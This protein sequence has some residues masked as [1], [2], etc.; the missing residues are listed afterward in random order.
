MICPHCGKETSDTEKFCQHCEGYISA[1]QTTKSTPTTTKTTPAAKP[2][3]RFKK[4]KA[5]GVTIGV[6]KTVCPVCGKNPN[7]LGG[8]ANT[9]RYDSGSFSFGFCMTFFLGIIG[10]IATLVKGGEETYRGAVVAELI[11]LGISA[12]V[13]LFTIIPKLTELLALLSQGGY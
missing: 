5:C 6:E 1:T 12:I 4:C 13:G 3:Q 10:L 9:R 7:V 2:A 11:S 8:G